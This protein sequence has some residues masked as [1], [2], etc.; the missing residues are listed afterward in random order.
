MLLGD[1]CTRACR[2]CNVK[3]GNPN[4]WTDKSEPQKTADSIKIMNLR[5]A[6]LTMVDRDDLNDGGAAHVAQVLST[7]KIANPDTKLEFLG[8]TSTAKL[9]ACRRY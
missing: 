6:V 7:V 3:T 4:G 1:T 5:Y 2:F 9:R 8:G